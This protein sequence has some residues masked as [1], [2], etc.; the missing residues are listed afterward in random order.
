MATPGLSGALQS[1]RLVGGRRVF[2]GEGSPL[3]FADIVVRDS[4]E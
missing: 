1:A 4:P 2:H 3:P